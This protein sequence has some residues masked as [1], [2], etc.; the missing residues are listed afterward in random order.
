MSTSNKPRVLLVDDEDH[1]RTLMKVVVSALGFDVV[2]EAS[3]GQRAL[4]MFHDT[5]PDI[6]ILDMNMPI[7]TGDEVLQGIMS[8]NPQALVIM[9]TS[10]VDV[11]SVERCLDL[12]AANYIRK[13]TP[14]AEM[15]TCLLETWNAHTTA[16]EETHEHAV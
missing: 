4:S 1:V 5:Q 8:T 2:A 3:N 10:V 9:L 13:D 14:I 16:H 15:K 12:G 11:Q 7:T 6:T